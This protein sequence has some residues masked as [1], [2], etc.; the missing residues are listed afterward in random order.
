VWAARDSIR[1]LSKEEATAAEKVEA[2]KR[3]QRD[4]LVPSDEV[5]FVQGS[6]KG[7]DGTYTMTTDVVV[8][9]R[10]IW[11]HKTKDMAMYLSNN[12]KWVVASNK[13][14]ARDGATSAL[15]TLAGH[16]EK[17]SPSSLD[18]RQWRTSIDK[19]WAVRDD[20]RVLGKEEAAAAE[21]AE[22]A[23][24]L[25]KLE[26][27]RVQR[28]RLVPSDEVYFI[29]GSSKDCDG[30]YTMTTDVVVNGRFIWEHKTKDRAMYLAHND[31]WMVSDKADARAGSTS[32]VYMILPGHGDKYSPSSLDTRQW[33]TCID[34]FRV[35]ADWAVRD[36]I[37]VLRLR[38]PAAVQIK[39]L[40]PGSRV[41]IRGLEVSSKL[42]GTDCIVEKF[43]KNK[44]RYTVRLRGGKAICIKEGNL[45]E[46]RDDIDGAQDKYEAVLRSEP[47]HADSLFSLGVL[48]Q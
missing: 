17:Y 39:R 21:K 12:G 32:A 18:T 6:S 30:A 25:A 3:A 36:G 24:V 15:M 23:A 26:E 14:Q 40:A 4:L 47:E 34:K 45:E 13:A 1:V 8:N 7:C 9:G 48:L 38:V 5:Y 31:K 27:D 42:N 29:Q 33:Q 11:E 22:A 46:W 16:S 41:I 20:I 10:F 28:D 35:M 37:R 44:G 43:I 2:T 19:V